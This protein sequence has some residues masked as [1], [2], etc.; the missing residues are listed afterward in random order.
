MEQLKPQHSY[1]LGSKLSAM[2]TIK[3]SKSRNSV[4]ICNFDLGRT[5]HRLRHSH[6]NR[7]A[8]HRNMRLSHRDPQ[9]S[10]TNSSSLKQQGRLSYKW[11]PPIFR[12]LFRL[13]NGS[14]RWNFDD[15]PKTGIARAQNSHYV[16]NWLREVFWNIQQLHTGRVGRRA[17]SCASYDH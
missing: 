7:L 9:A 14:L 5:N 2:I 1:N 13:M 6:G 12:S 11:I 15:P 16:N 3:S 10:E 17:A 4:Y 8:L